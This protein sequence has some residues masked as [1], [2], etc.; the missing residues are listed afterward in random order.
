MVSRPSAT[1]CLVSSRRDANF[2]AVDF[3]ELLLPVFAPVMSDAM[4]PGAAC[5]ACLVTQH[6]R[7]RTSRRHQ[8]FVAQ[9]H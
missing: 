2:G 6:V 7:K 4:V 3:L 9:S 1:L 5:K 8:R